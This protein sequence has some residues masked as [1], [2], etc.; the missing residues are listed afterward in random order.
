[1]SRVRVRRETVLRQTLSAAQGLLAVGLVGGVVW[2]AGQ[3]AVGERIASVD[4]ARPAVAGSDFR[5]TTVA[6]ERAALSCPGPEL[7]GLAGARDVA[8]ATEATLVAAPLGELSEIPTPVG[9]AELELTATTGESVSD[10]AAEEDSGGRLTA[11][12]ESVTSYLAVGAGVAAP[13]LVAT[14]ETRAE[15]EEVVG[16]ATVPC[17]I[18]GPEVWLL[19]G[20]GGP[21]RAER[22]ILANPG[23]NPVTVD[24]TAFGAEGTSAP[25]AGQ[26][27]T[28]PALGRVV[29]LGDALAPDEASPA[30]AVTAT[31]GDVAAVLVET[32]IEGTR[33]TGFD[34]SAAAAAPAEEQVI[35]G[36]VVPAEDGGTLSARIVN[37]GESEAIATIS[38]LSSAG[39]VP[40]PE[41]VVRVPAG[42]A[43]D[44]PVP[45]VPP[46]TTSLIVRADGAVLAGVRT[47]IDSGGGES[48]GVDASW[49]LAQPAL[50]AL[51]GAAVPAREGV[52]RSLV[53]AAPSG[54][55]TVEVLEVAAG[56]ATTTELLVPS[57]GTVVHPV[58]GDGVWTRATDGSGAV[59]AAVVSTK[60]EGEA[61]AVSSMPLT[62][63]PTSSR[64]SEVVPLP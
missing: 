61:A 11:P 49:A 2:A 52:E 39:E 17:Q 31:G 42:S 38:V 21:G 35:P 56:A 28:I 23:G 51:A 54:A 40:L 43:V 58:T 64:R 63:P 15:T 57:G 3:P 20:G 44:V 32:A 8:L 18:A 16:L 24:I 36:V 1:M 19:G 48:D 5:S 60:A 55:A 53:V 27:L 12:L 4:V 59:H 29:L 37:P 33:P 25:P 46:G 30:F 22:L 6:L 45:D 26:G 14:Q 50:S 62:V 9:P 10:P 13:G 47:V 34:V 7:L 41:A